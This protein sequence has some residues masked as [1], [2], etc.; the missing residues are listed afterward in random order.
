MCGCREIADSRGC[1]GLSCASGGFLGYLHDVICDLLCCTINTA[2]LRG[3][4]E[5]RGL[6]DDDEKRPDVITVLPLM[7]GK[8]WAA[9]VTCVNTMVPTYLR[10]T[11]KKAGSRSAGDKRLRPSLHFKL[12]FFSE[13][14]IETFGSYG[15]EATKMI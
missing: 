13:I 6:C 7:R 8:P 11:T 3:R 5:P 2:G 15:L 10:K 4:R 9:D 14:G 12:I 1:H